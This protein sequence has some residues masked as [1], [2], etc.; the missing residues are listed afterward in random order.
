MDISQISHASDRV[1]IV[2][3][4]T[5]SLSVRLISGQLNYLRQLGFEV[6]LISS[7]GE[8]LSRVRT[9]EGVST[10]SMP[11]AR[12][13]AFWKDLRALWMLW[14]VM[15]RLRPSIVNFSTPKAA[16]L[17]AI[18][19]WLGRVPCRIYMLRGLRFETTVGLKRFGLVLCEHIA[20]RCAT[21]VICVSQSLRRKAV[22]MGLVKRER[23]IV[24]A[25]GS[26]NG[27]EEFRFTSGSKHTCS[28]A[29]LCLDLGVPPEAPV[30]GFVGRLTKD[31]G[32]GELVE[33]YLVLQAKIPEL[34]LLLVGDTEEGDPL[35]PE[36]CRRIE[37]TPGIIRTGFVQD[38]APYYHLM[39]VLALPTHREG[40]PNVVLEAHAAGKPVV[41][42]LATGVV[43]AVI[44]GATGI[45]VPVG[46][47]HA[48]ANALAHV[49]EDRRLAAALGSAGRERV[50]R[51]FRQ[52]IVWDA[53]AQEYLQLLH[54]KGLTVPT[55]ATRNEAAV[56]LASGAALSQ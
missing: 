12:E 50:L 24:I 5:S 41:A 18:A 9:L 22:A 51:E 11:M 23:A 14:R 30:I 35:P 49:I 21:R 33:A 38:P 13:I 40:F 53:L 39:D 46:D 34:R 1:R 45:L 4:V 48:L 31:K 27:V 8:E 25:S 42:A 29:L 15:R 55:A 10:V 47:Y 16:L 6:F 52:E 7:S 44:N 43:D 26:S 2:Y 20:C 37:T 3:V 54:A 19:A 28:A 56:E 32:I 17:G 36:I